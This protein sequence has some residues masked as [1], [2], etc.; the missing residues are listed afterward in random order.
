MA[1]GIDFRCG[2]RYQCWNDSGERTF[3]IDVGAEV[4]KLRHRDA[5]SF[6]DLTKLAAMSWKLLGHSE[7]V[8]DERS[9]HA[10]RRIPP[11]RPRMATR[12]TS[13]MALFVCVTEGG[14]NSRPICGDRTTSP[15][16]TLTPPSRAWSAP[17][18][19]LSGWPAFELL[20]FLPSRYQVCQA[21]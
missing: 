3:G 20:C 12:E 15:S 4:E 2:F 14:R 11:A 6:C 19:A 1:L 9:T 5:E 18:M 16:Y 21:A 8:L 10:P 17:A 13:R 7:V